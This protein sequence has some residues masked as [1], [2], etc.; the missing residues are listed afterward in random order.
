MDSEARFAIQRQQM[1][2]S[3]LRSEGIRDERVLA[4]MATVPRH[5]FV[6]EREQARAYQ[7]KPLPIAENQTISQPY[8]VAYMLQTLNL[9]QSDKVL[10]IGTGSGYQAALL[11]VLCGEVH[12]V[13]RHA[14]LAASAAR[15]LAELQITNVH[16]HRGDG[17]KGWP[18]DAPY[19]A[20]VVSAAAPKAPQT[21]LDELNDGGRMI[22]PVGKA[23][24]QVLQ[25]WTRNGGKFQHEDLVP[26]AFVP[27]IGAHGWQSERAGG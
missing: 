24:S 26:V 8:I 2:V 7:D 11:S 27:L 5:R 1:V 15:V 22:I 3:Q 21:L 20:I 13:E 18:A 6:R 25:L 16:V 23:G 9:A 12:T 19:D 14:Q 10:E 17:S 4:A